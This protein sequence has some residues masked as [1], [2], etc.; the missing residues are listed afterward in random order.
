[1]LCVHIRIASTRRFLWVHST[2]NYRAENRKDFPKL[3]LFASWPGA[4]I[5][6]QWLE[7]LIS[8]TN[9]HG[10]IDVRAIEVRLYNHKHWDETKERAR[11]RSEARTQEN[12]KKITI[13][14]TT[15]IDIQGPTICTDWRG[16]GHLVWGSSS[17]LYA[18]SKFVWM[19]RHKKRKNSSDG[20]SGTSGQLKSARN[21]GSPVEAHDLLAT[22][23]IGLIRYFIVRVQT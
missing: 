2:Y 8:R 20:T 19:G 6:P 11:W 13:G 22:F 5:N 3:S 14:S 7:L 21:G 18:D 16:S 12:Q 15:D 9:F 17:I 10:P 23:C 1:M 4:M